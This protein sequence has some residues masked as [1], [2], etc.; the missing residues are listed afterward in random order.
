MHAHSDARADVNLGAAPVARRSLGRLIRDYATL[1]KPSIVL[2]L[3]ITTVP[4]MV[5]A[6]G[7]WPSTWLVI[8]TL[9][10]GMLA[11]GGAAA[12]NMYIDRDIDAIMSRTRSRPVPRGAVPARHALIFGLAQGIASGIWLALT[13]NVISAVLAIAAFLFYTVVYSLY[14]KRTTVHNTVLGGAAGAAPPLIG[15][16]AVTGHIGLSGVMLFLIV[17]YWQPPHFW[18]LAL[19]LAD[20]YRAAGIPMMPVV[21]GERETKRQIV[22][23]AILTVAVTLIFGAVAG[24][25]LLYLAVATLGGIGFVWYALRI[26]RSPGTAGTRAMFRYSTSYLAL[27][28]AS[29][30]MDRLLLG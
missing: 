2:L 19:G 9:I 15:W 3:L 13:V 18:A 10:G 6:N 5:L 26:Y 11:S 22:L 20:D 30:V 4:A 14:L 29:M 21:V 27:L 16:T 12:V 28:F 1:T 25:N 24:L 7:G 8:A 17:F 23:Y